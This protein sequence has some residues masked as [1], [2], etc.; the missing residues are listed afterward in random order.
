MK[1]WVYHESALVGPYA[2]EEI[3]QLQGFSSD[4][5]V[6]PEGRLDSGSDQWQRAASVPELAMPIL[7]S[8]WTDAR[9]G[10]WGG[11]LPPEPTFDDAAAV[12]SLKEKIVLL[13]NAVAVVRREMTAQAEAKAVLQ[14]ELERQQGE[15][16][17]VQKRLA[18]LE[19]KLTLLGDLK[20]QSKNLETAAK[21]GEKLAA[22]LDERASALK[23]G[24]RA[25]VLGGLEGLKEEIAKISVGLRDAVERVSSL[26][27]GPAAGIPPKSARHGAPAGVDAAPGADLSP[28]GA[29]GEQ[30]DFGF[31]SA[32]LLDDPEGT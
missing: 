6:C 17:Q 25:Q 31:P 5:L 24:L 18:S 3:S 7:T 12:G 21:T 20:E 32:S 27:A 26:P 28:K 9:G 10:R 8:A 29:A 11:M 15:L 4:S 19:D 2:P 22:E 1:Y 13:A 14:I 16:S 30:D 23:E